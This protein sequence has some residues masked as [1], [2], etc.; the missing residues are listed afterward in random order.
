MSGYTPV[1]LD[2]SGGI[3]SKAE[4]ERTLEYEVE[5]DRAALRHATSE[6]VPAL[7]AGLAGAQRNLTMLHG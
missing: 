3:P 2:Q 6:Q 4:L 1:P 5:V 7:E